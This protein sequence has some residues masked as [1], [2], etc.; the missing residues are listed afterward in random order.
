MIVKV[1]SE[2]GFCFGVEDAIEIA[3]HAVAE[4]GPGQVVALGPV[5]HNKDV[6]GKLEREGLSQSGELDNVDS[7][8]TLLIRSHGATPETLQRAADRGLEIVDATCVL[9]KR[10]QQV[11]SQL[12]EDGY[13]VVM[14]GDPNHPEVRGVIGYAPVVTVIDRDTNLEEAL[15]YKERLGIV[16]QTTHSPEH[17][18]AVIARILCRPYRE[19]KIVNTLCLEVTRRQEAAVALAAEVEVMFVLGGLH[20]A[21]TKEL[22]RLC[23][24]AGCEA[25]HLEGWD[26]FDVGMVKGK[27]V[28][29][30]TAGASTPGDVID[31]F[32][33]LLEQ[34]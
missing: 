33:R 30:V 32:V 7:S 23:V 14:I 29:G 1:A 8:K 17:V 27:K 12:H 11:V 31:D 26:Q 5:I 9:V 34:I 20:S 13:H 22:A 16:A 25:H 24:E 18:A 10:A 6:V 2:K 4:R 15:P 28:A 19:V 21:N 3:Q